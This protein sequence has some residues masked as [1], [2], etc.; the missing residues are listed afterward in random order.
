GI[1]AFL[2]THPATDD[3]LARLERIARERGWPAE[4][5]LTPLPASLEAI[6]RERRDDDRRS[7][8]GLTHRP[9]DPQIRDAVGDDA[10]RARGGPR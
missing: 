6:R 7:R 3:R 5:A 8:V 10:K 2:R 4:G 9:G 1:P